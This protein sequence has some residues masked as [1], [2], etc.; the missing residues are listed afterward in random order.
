[1]VINFL[2]RLYINSPAHT[3]DQRRVVKFLREIKPL[4]NK[5]QVVEIG[6]GRGVGMQL[7]LEA[8]SPE[9]AEALDVDPRMIRLAERRLGARAAG[10]VTCRL[11]DAQ[12]LPHAD[13]S[14]DAVFDFGVLHHLEDWRR[15]LSEVARI[16]KGGGLFY[17]EEYFPHLYANA[18]FGR[19]LVHP[20]EDRFENAEFHTALTSA[21][22]RMLSG[23][24]ESA[25]RLLGVAV[26]EG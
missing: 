8:F 7:I 3:V 18:L 6:C 12:N 20:R 5:S 11:S 4:P 2:E 26:K 19:L 15:G 17:I 25:S 9:R 16:L 21:G 14:V 1:M 10:R 24:R 13:G 23:A 22:F